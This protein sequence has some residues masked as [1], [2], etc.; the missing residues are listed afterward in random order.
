MEKVYKRNLM[1]VMLNLIIMVFAV[2]FVFLFVGYFGGSKAGFIASGIALLLALTMI[3]KESRIKVVV[4]DN[5][6]SV[7]DGKKAYH[8]N[9]DEVSI[10]SKSA[11]Y[12]TFSICYYYKWRKRLF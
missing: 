9:L 6:F 12:Q 5:D 7:Y 2:V 3:Y 1:A 8:Y 11:D 4:H 10:Q